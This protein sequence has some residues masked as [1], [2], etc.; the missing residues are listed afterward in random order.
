MAKQIDIT[1]KLDFETNPKLII[2][3]EKYEVNADAPTVLKLMGLMGE[4]TGIKEVLKSYELI[5]SEKTREKIEELK[6][7][8]SDLVTII[9]EAINLVTGENESRG[10]Q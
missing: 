4:N 5:F 3:D 2:K 9:E 10:E 8:F 6:P 7:S 1:D